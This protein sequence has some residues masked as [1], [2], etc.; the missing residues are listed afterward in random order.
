AVILCIVT[1]PTTSTYTLSLHDALPI[2]IGSERLYRKIVVPVSVK[3]KNGIIS[4]RN[5]RII[6]QGN[7]NPVE[8]QIR[9]IDQDPNSEFAVGTAFEK[10]ISVLGK[11]SERRS[12]VRTEMKIFPGFVDEHLQLIAENQFFGPDVIAAVC[13]KL[14]R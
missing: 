4:H 2:Y 1:P 3:F 12:S 5:F 6:H 8:D 13:G 10:G 7:L 14:Q 11:P 9:I